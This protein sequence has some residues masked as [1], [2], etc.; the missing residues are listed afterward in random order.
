MLKLSPSK[1]LPP[2]TIERVDFSFAQE[3]H[4]LCGEDVWRCY[5]CGKCLAGCPSAQAMD[6]APAEV[7]RLI[8]L[9]QREAVLSSKGIWVCASC[10]TCTTRCPMEI[11]IA[12]VMDAC[13]ALSL[14]EGKVHPEAKRILAFHEAFLFSV[15]KYGRAHEVS[16]VQRFKLRTLDFFNFGDVW[17]GLVMFLKGKLSPFGH[18]IKGKDEVEAYFEEAKK[19]TQQK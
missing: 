3:I 13:R 5:Q 7:M 17:N 14:R 15:R 4:D 19:E 9:G 12:A 10:Q 18:K 8:Q 11:D 6:V 16:M 2:A 1:A